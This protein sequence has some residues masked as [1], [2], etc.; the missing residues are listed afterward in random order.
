[1]IFHFNS[2]SIELLRK[3]RKRRRRYIKETKSPT[4]NRVS[5]YTSNELGSRQTYPSQL[6]PFLVDNFCNINLSPVTLSAQ[7]AFHQAQSNQATATKNRTHWISRRI[8]RL[9]VLF[10]K[11]SEHHHDMRVWS[12][13]NRPGTSK[14]RC[15]CLT[16]TLDRELQLIWEEELELE[17][18]ERV[19]FL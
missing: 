10:A 9:L 1:M 12:H 7:L 3:M 17:K 15:N 11:G 16:E 6:Q 18:E 19:G 13:F 2:L 4:A 8:L 5:R 14:F